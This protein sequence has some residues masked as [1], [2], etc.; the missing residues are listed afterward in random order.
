MDK[1]P[2]DTK[3][4]L[5]SEEDFEALYEAQSQPIY[6]FLYWRT[7]D[8]DLSEDLTSSVFEKAWKKRFS[9]RGG[10]AKA[11]LYRIARNLLIDHWRSRKDVAIEGTEHLPDE[12]ASELGTQFD[13]TIRLQQLQQALQQLSA[14]MR[15]IVKL[16]FIEGLSAK[17]V[18]DK[19]HLSEGNVRVIQYRALKKMRRHIGE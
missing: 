8:T 7:H 4:M 13:Q 10:S 17:E 1:E 6:R 2:S 3:D 16:R 18:A 11:W 5:E 15:S 19:L 14:E 9:F 12:E